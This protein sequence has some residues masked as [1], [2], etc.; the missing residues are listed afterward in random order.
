MIFLY[1]LIYSILIPYTTILYFPIMIKKIQFFIYK[2][3]WILIYFTLNHIRILLVLT[4]I[5]TLLYL[6][7][8]FGIVNDEEKINSIL[9][10]LIDSAGIVSAIALAFLTQRLIRIVEEKKQRKIKIDS[11]TKRLHQFR[12][13]LDF[14]VSECYEHEAD[15]VKAKLK[16]PKLTNFLLKQYS[17]EKYP[18][19]Y[20]TEM[21]EKYI[22]DKE[23]NLRGKFEVYLAMKDL[24]DEPRNNETLYWSLNKLYKREYS[25]EEIEIYSQA[26]ST[27]WYYLEN[28][29]PDNIESVW[30]CNQSKYYNNSWI[31]LAKE[32]LF[33]ISKNKK[34]FDHSFIAELANDFH[35][36]DLPQL[37]E[38]TELNQRGIP[39][40]LWHIIGSLCVLLFFGVAL[41]LVILSFDLGIYGYS[42]TLL[43]LIL[44]VTTFVYLILE[45]ILLARKEIKV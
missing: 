1:I 33:Q 28:R 45:V 32:H 44:V 22:N 23:I 41:P 35:E 40:E 14:I 21:I 8:E 26:V 13:G 27:I 10:K 9:D 12:K 11:I 16:Y 36:V 30:V 15:I 5:S 18:G 3:F 42:F 34:E 2:I 38:L 20:P 24:V 6:Q 43:S 31:N 7:N 29:L 37:Y 4:L 39:K 19:G 25:L 17:L